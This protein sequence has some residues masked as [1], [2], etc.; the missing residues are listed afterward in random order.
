MVLAPVPVLLTAPGL[1]VSVQVPTAGRPLK[2]TLPV[3]VV[4]V[5]GVIVP[6]IGAVGVAGCGLISTLL[7]A[8]EVQPSALVTVKV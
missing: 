7:E 5:G 2:A 3:A 8:A 4:Q 1:R 6:T